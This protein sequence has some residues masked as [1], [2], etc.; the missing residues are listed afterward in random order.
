VEQDD[1]EDALRTLLKI[2]DDTGHDIHGGW[3]AED[4]VFEPLPASCRMGI[5]IL[6]NSLRERGVDWDDLQV[7]VAK[8]WRQTE[9]LD[10]IIDSVLLNQASAAS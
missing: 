4:V 5:I 7:R 6:I 2:V 10:G 1:I 9:I 8:G 3:S